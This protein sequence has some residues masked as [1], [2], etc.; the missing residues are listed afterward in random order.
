MSH[1]GGE[2][3]AGAQPPACWLSRG[4]SGSAAAATRQPGTVPA[5][6][7]TPDLGGA[8]LPSTRFKT[9]RMDLR[10]FISSVPAPDPDPTDQHVFGPPGSGSLV[11]GM[12][13]APDPDPSII[14]LSSS[15]NSRKT[16]IPIVL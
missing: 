15:K 2:R 7:S 6:S 12:D 10:L 1:A 5:A 13:P 8:G 11:R 9:T 14:I 16:L 3:G 4:W